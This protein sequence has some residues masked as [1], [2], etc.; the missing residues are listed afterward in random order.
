MPPKPPLK[1]KGKG[2]AKQKEVAPPPLP[3]ATSGGN[4]EAKL[5]EVLSALSLHKDQ[6]PEHLQTLVTSQQASDTA[7]SAKAMHKQV[8]PQENYGKELATLQAQRLE[9]ERSWL[10]YVQ[11]LA[12]KFIEQMAEK[13]QVVANYA[14]REGKLQLLVKQAKAQ[15]LAMAGGSEGLQ[16][17]K[18][19]DMDVATAA[20]EQSLPDP[21]QEPRPGRSRT[22]LRPL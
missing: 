15:V 19:E 1:G 2:K 8:A 10:T 13:R 7:F 11:S 14:E 20:P 21:W 17:Q 22:H 4:A 9:Y 16:D 18:A 12:D 6:L 5:A 3:A